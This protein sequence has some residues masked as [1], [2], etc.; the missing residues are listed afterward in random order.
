M[1]TEVHILRDI[2]MYVASHFCNR[3]HQS[4]CHLYNGEYG[5]IVGIYSHDINFHEI[6]S[7]EINSYKINFSWVQLSLNKINSLN[8]LIKLIKHK[9]YGTWRWSCSSLQPHSFLWSGSCWATSLV[10][11]ASQEL[12]VTCTI[13][14]LGVDIPLKLKLLFSMV[15]IDKLSQD[16]DEYALCWKSVA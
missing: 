5:Y 10:V 4:F 15:G 14:Y 3:M 16:G 6:N 7:H 9:Q 1:Q 12:E 13:S 8:Q 2:Y 11:L